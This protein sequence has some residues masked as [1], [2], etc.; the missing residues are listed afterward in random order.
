MRIAHPAASTPLPHDEGPIER[1][2]LRVGLVGPS[3]RFSYDAQTGAGWCD[4]PVDLDAT[5]LSDEHVAHAG[6]VA[7]RDHP[8]F[9]GAFLGMWVM[10]LAGDGFFADFDSARYEL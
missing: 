5:I 9:T 6:V 4:V 1:I 10:D 3:A 7:G 2:R 8:G